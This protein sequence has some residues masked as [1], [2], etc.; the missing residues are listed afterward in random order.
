MEYAPENRKKVS[1]DSHIDYEFYMR[2]SVCLFGWKV[3][4][5]EFEYYVWDVWDTMVQGN[6]SIQSG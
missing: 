3:K 1:M 6:C 5:K 2:R 4:I